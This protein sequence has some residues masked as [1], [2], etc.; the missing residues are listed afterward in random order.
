MIAKA[1]AIGLDHLPLL[2][3]NTQISQQ[4][5]YNSTLF[6]SCIAH[7]KLNE[8]ESLKAEFKV[9]ISYSFN[10]LYQAHQNL[11]EK[12]IELGKI[13]DITDYTGYISWVDS[14]EETYS[15]IK[16]NYIGDCKALCQQL[17]CII[18]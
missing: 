9:N 13:D 15:E 11:I 10:K 1:E 7:K 2:K 3:F 16:P 14:I 5:F 18:C 4:H 8:L 6:Y 12:G 17:N